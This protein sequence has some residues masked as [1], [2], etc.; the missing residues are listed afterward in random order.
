MTS[1][2]THESV[3]G[4]QTI[5]RAAALLRLIGANN[6]TGMRLVDL[7]TAAGLERPTAHRLLQGLIAERLVRQDSKTKHYFLGSLMYEMGLAAAP[8]AD[9]RDICHPHLLSIADRTG[10]TVFLT[11]R[12]SFDGVCVDRAEGAYPIKVFVLEVGRRRPLNVGAGSV[13]ILSALSDEE[14]DR[15]CNVNAEVL[16]ERFPRYSETL[17]RERIARARETGYVIQDVLEV[18]NVRSIAAPIR[19]ANGRPIGAISVS[20]LYSRLEGDRLETVSSYLFEA[21]RA[22]QAGSEG[23]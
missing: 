5:E 23:C 4:T 14:V 12:S 10:D 19:S 8:K 22:I 6:R 2:A 11:L 7:Y 1:K 9:L 13:A 20:A 16:R 15:I 21:I 17:M 3:R 18:E